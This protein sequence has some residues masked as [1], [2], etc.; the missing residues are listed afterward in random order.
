MILSFHLLFV[1]TEETSQMT[2]LFLTVVGKDSYSQIKTLLA[3]DLPSSKKYAD[4]KKIVNAHL[5]PKTIEIAERYKFHMT[6]QGHDSVT[7]FVSKLRKAAETCN[8]GT[9]LDSMLR[10]RFVVGLN[11]DAVVRKL[12]LEDSLSFDKAVMI[13]SMSEEV[14]NCQAAMKSSEPSH[15]NKVQTK[16][17]NNTNKQSNN[18]LCKFCG[19]KHARKECKAFGK[20]CT[21]KRGGLRHTG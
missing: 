1:K 12:L 21:V 14:R 18:F 8:F 16:E 10:D 3:P 9:Q 5:K 11:D 17:R 20:M 7:T 13:A 6:K 19:F 15:V 2:D 4:I